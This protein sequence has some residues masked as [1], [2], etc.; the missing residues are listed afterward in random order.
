MWRRRRERAS[1]SVSLCTAL[2][3]FFLFLRVLLGRCCGLL[4]FLSLFSPLLFDHVS[5]FFS[6]PPTPHST[7]GELACPT[8]R[9]DEAVKETVSCPH[10]FSLTFPLLSQH[11]E[12][13]A[14][15]GVAYFSPKAFHPFYTQRLLRE[16]K[17]E[18]GTHNR[19]KTRIETPTNQ[20]TTASAAP[21]RND[22][23]D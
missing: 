23:R 12:P 18:R 21:K 6:S 3:F 19:K 10:C 22:E 2:N 13:T 17:G 8:P 9:K 11:N 1:L 4:L 15:G 16:L 7:R 20:L 5:P 14:T